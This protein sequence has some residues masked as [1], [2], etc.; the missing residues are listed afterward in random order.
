MNRQT[1]KKS[2]ASVLMLLVAWITI[3][4]F[5]QV[6]GKVEADPN[7]QQ[8]AINRGAA[9][10]WQSL[11]ELHTR[12]SLI[13][14]TAHPDDEDG[15]VLTYESRYVGADTTLFTL[16]RG[17]GGQNVMS[18][19]FWD[20]LGLVRTEE[21]LAADR[22][23]GVHQYWSRVADFGFTKTK[24]EA[25]KKW[26]YDRV[27]YDSVRVVRMTRPLVVTSVFAGNVSDGHGQHQV[28][29]Q[30]AQEVYKAAADPNVFPDQIRAGLR[31]WAPLKVY[32]RLPFATITNEG[33]Y[34]YATGNWAPA[35]F[36]NYVNNTWIDG[37]PSP[38]LEIPEGQYNPALGLSY[39]QIARRGL[40]QQKSQN[41]GIGIPAAG[42]DFSAY[43]LYASRVPANAQEKSFFD[44]ID[45]SLAGIA[46][47]APAD[48]AGWI[49]DKLNSI[50]SLVEQAMQNFSVDA[51]EKIAPTLATGL[52][53]TE[54]LI[55]EIQ[56]KPLPEDARYNMLHELNIKRVQFNTA[57][58]QALA[59]SLE[60]TVAD[61]TQQGIATYNRGVSET[62]QAAIPGQSFDVKVHLANQGSEPVAVRD[63]RLITIPDKDWTLSAAGATPDKLAAGEADDIRFAVTA[64]NNA[65]I[66]KPYFTRPDIEQPYYDIS[67]PAYL[68]LS[69]MP[70]PLS[71]RVTFRYRGVDIVSDQVVQTVHRISGLG[72]VENPLIVS[73]AISVW[74]SPAAGV[75]PLTGKSLKI[76]A[77]IH[78][79]VKG[80]ATGTVSLQLPAGWIST[81]RQANFSTR[82]DGDEQNIEF[83]VIP[84][85]VQA[86]PYRI[87]AAVIYG[88]HSYTSGSTMVGYPG[89]RPYP[90]Y[91]DASYRATGVDIHLPSGMKIGY[92]TGTGDSVPGSL[93]DLGIQT[94]FLSA[95]D[96]AMADLTSFN[97]IILGV[98]AYAVR[99]ELK[100]F[101][102]RLLEYAK[103]GGTL[104]VQYNTPEFDHNYGPYPYELSGNP[105]KVIDEKSKVT[106]LDPNYPAFTWPNK[107]TAQDF[108]GWIEER[109][110]GFMHEWD[111]RYT[112]LTET[113]DPD[114][115]PQKGGLLVVSYGRGFYVYDA[116]ALYRQ[117]PEGVPGAFRIFANLLS[118][119]SNP[120]MR[121]LWAAGG[122]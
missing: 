6:S 95:Q 10:L 45:V 82:Q 52:L 51:P 86:R 118:L 41:G 5:G 120:G 23:Y 58:V 92:V 4:A 78:S 34:D 113:H 73:P 117:L 74:V 110:H 76:T 79:N 94:I 116:Y 112:A 30:M 24:E 108:D 64:S 68:N 19:D 67:T 40:D 103:D 90:Y 16:N 71:A 114:Q 72:P 101:N 53:Q 22:Y 3:P 63:V 43:H 93:E 11:R 62:F 35:R 26:G 60:A 105:E 47:Y 66:T 75:V 9:A 49:H 29:G 27:L 33:V 88:G 83:V 39:I 28:S 84:G 97:A 21:L 89:L 59:V 104:I 80:P 46:D 1:V 13:M 55:Q 70:Y 37:K 99:P 12:A 8:I 69:F 109:G 91:R 14:F 122:N 48:Q 38:T 15:G 50:N 20:Q 2:V 77:L 57:L 85:T 25:L 42:P 31:P 102:A 87:T 65:T 106:L 18:S 96:I 7:A 56:Q 61:G 107:I 100:A 115:A 32:V 121:K 36:R 98:R 81:P 119:S 54:A 17:E 44:G 111:P